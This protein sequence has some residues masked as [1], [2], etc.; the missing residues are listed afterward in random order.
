MNLAKARNQPFGYSDSGHLDAV[1]HFLAAFSTL[2]SKD[3]KKQ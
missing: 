1:L 2:L 3:G